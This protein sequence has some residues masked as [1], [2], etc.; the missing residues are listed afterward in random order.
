MDSEWMEHNWIRWLV[1][2]ALAGGFSWIM[3]KV[4]EWLN[5]LPFPWNFI[6]EG[7]VIITYGLG[8]EHIGLLGGREE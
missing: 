6:A 5:T 8:I 4:G 2:G 7:V 3:F 1:K